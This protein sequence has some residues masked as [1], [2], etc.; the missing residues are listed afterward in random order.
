VSEAAPPCLRVTV[1]GRPEAAYDK[2]QRLAGGQRRAL[3]EMDADMDG[4]FELGGRQVS[5]PEPWERAQ[6]VAMQLLIALDRGDDA[7]VT[8]TSAYLAHRHPELREVR[9]VDNGEW[10]TLELI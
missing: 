2:T 9:A 3:D 10:V 4:G 7:L 8:L 1:N 5:R 6:F